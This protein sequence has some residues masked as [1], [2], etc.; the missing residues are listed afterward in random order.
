M[1][2]ELQIEKKSNFSQKPEF[3]RFFLNKNIYKN[4]SARAEIYFKTS[5]MPPVKR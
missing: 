4:T 2:K 5:L 3:V 1:E